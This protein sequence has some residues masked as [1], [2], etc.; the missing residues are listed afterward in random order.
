MST[1]DLPNP[2]QDPARFNPALGGA[3]LS[4]QGLSPGYGLPDDASLT[5][6]ANEIFSSPPGTPASALP[7]APAV[8]PPHGLSPDFSGADPTR[9]TPSLGGAGFSPQGIA[10]GYGLPD[11]ASLA[12]LAHEAVSFAPG[13]S[14]GVLPGAPN[15]PVFAPPQVPGPDVPLN[16]PPSPATGAGPAGIPLP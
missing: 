15:P 13:V 4:P 14:A 11:E 5:R 9:I 16:T 7:G 10:P 8:T 12:R 2:G 3:G 1:S 6:L